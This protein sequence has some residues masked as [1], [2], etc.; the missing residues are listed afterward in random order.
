MMIW[1]GKQ[2][3]RQ[4]DKAEVKQESH[5]IVIMRDDEPGNEDPEAD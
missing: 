3:L 5:Q 1:L 2:I 4:S